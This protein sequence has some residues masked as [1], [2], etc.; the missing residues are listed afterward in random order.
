VFRA[1]S[2]AVAALA[3]QGFRWGASY[4]DFQHFQR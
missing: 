4:R 2:A 3:R 1:R